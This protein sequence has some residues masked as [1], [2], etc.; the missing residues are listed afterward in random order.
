M[1]YPDGGGLTAQRRA[2]REAVRLPARGA[3][4]SQYRRRI[5]RTD[6]ADTCTPSLRTPPRCAHTPSVGSP[7]HPRHH[8]DHLVSQ[9]GSSPAGDRI[10][11]AAGHQ[12]ALSTQQ[13]RRRDQKDRPR[14]R[15]NSRANIA[16][17]SRSCGVYRGQ[18]TCRRTTINWCRSTAI[19]TS[20][21]P[22]RDRHQPG[23]EPD[24]RS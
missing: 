1:R 5:R 18:A 4:P 24:G 14:S 3:G 7:G 16:N 13:R 10:G 9:A 12:L 17:T 22:V 6:V 19:S 21:H 8:L 20:L 11:P 15:G 2:N 23:R